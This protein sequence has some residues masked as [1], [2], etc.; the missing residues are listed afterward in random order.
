MVGNA[1]RPLGLYGKHTSSRGDQSLDGGISYML[2]SI[3]SS[4]VDQKGHLSA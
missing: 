3:A 1:R 4:A 2:S